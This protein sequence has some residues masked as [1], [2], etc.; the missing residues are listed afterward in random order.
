ME[1]VS[2]QDIADMKEKGAIILEDG[3][4]VDWLL[5]TIDDTALEKL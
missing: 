2:S 4:D 5:K 3:G 1:N